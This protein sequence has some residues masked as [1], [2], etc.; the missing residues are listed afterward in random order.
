MKGIDIDLEKAARMAPPGTPMPITAAVIDH[1]TH[2]KAGD[3][4]T[5][6]GFDITFRSKNPVLENT[7][8][9]LSVRNPAIRAGAEFYRRTSPRPR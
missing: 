3:E 5:G 8:I 9:I 7:Y 6:L 4:T 1:C 2:Q